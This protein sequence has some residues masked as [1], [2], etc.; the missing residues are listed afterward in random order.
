MMTFEVGGMI[1]VCCFFVPANALFLHLLTQTTQWNAEGRGTWTPELP[2]ECAGSPASPQS[3][4]PAVAAV[5]TLRRGEMT[6]QACGEK[7]G[8]VEM[9]ATS[10]SASM[11]ALMSS[12]KWH[13][14][15][16]VR[17]VF[18]L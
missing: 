18:S 12:P 8:L 1:I 2:A 17:V 13:Q 4:F 7:V 6:A 14:L 11:L 5:C 15:D 3:P 10:R 9:L 16:K